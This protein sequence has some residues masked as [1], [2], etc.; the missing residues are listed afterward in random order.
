[1]SSLRLLDSTRVELD[2]ASAAHLPAMIR[3]ASDQGIGV[4]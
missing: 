4:T 3:R 1:M 2:L